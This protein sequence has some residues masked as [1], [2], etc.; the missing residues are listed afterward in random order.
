[1]KFDA[2]LKALNNSERVAIVRKVYR[3]G[4]R[5]NLG[6]MSPDMVRMVSEKVLVIIMISY[7]ILIPDAHNR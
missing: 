3:K 5:V 6:V 4:T 2:L 7:V 1:M